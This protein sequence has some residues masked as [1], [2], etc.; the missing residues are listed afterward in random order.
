[1][2]A[3]A[4][5][6]EVV[7][8][9]AELV[10]VLFGA[11]EGFPCVFQLKPDVPRVLGGPA[12]FC[13][14]QCEVEGVLAGDAD[15]RER[16][17][18][19]AGTVVC[20]VEYE[21]GFDPVDGH[22]VTLRHFGKYPCFSAVLQHSG[23]FVANAVPQQFF[24]KGECFVV[25]YDLVFV[26]VADVGKIPCDRNAFFGCHGLLVDVPV[27]PG[28]GECLICGLCLPD[29]CAESVPCGFSCFKVCIHV[30]FLLIKVK[31]YSLCISFVIC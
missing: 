16:C 17:L 31:K 8:L 23:G 6:G 3:N 21:V 4:D 14:A 13:P 2:V 24:G 18:K 11:Q 5:V 1:M 12:S 7:H 28:E 20:V 19:G 26:D 27:E 10:H 29:V 25:L 15:G 22:L 30:G 9:I